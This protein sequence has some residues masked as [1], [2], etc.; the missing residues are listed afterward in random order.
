[1]AAT[2]IEVPAELVDEI[3]RTVGAEHRS[4]FVVDALTAGLQRLRQYQLAEAAAGTL[5]A[6]AVPEWSTRESTVDWVRGLRRG[7]APTS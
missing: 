4:S 5:D 6:A 1:M 2:H 7:D 3:D